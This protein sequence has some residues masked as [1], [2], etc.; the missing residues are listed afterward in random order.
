MFLPFC[1]GFNCYHSLCF[2]F[3]ATIRNMVVSVSCVIT[4]LGLEGWS[5]AT[6]AEDSA[7]QYSK[8][9]RNYGYDIIRYYSML[10]GNSI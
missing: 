6:K 3:D 8:L 2:V 7:I 1:K 4:P 10:F 5:V 9:E